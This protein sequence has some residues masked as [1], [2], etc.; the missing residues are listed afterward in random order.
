MVHYL[1]NDNSLCRGPPNVTVLD[2]DSLSSDCVC[3]SVSHCNY[4]TSSEMD[5][6]TELIRTEF[7]LMASSCFNS[8]FEYELLPHL[9]DADCGRDL[10][11]NQEMNPIETLN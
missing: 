6:V 8:S 9:M 7:A 2:L 5:C 1:W 4:W 10:V 3:G 11:R